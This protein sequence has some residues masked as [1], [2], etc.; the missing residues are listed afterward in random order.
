MAFIVVGFYLYTGACTDGHSILAID[1]GL[2]LVANLAIQSILSSEA[3]LVWLG[4]LLDS[5]TPVTVG[6]A[7]LVIQAVFT[8]TTFVHPKIPLF[9]TEDGAY[10]I[11]AIS[12]DHEH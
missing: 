4:S 3:D 8:V 11:P 9:R 6:L 1:I 2:L 7:V 5:A 10:G 12:E